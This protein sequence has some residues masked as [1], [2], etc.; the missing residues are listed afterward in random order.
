M[1]RYHLEFVHLC[2]LSIKFR[3]YIIINVCAFTEVLAVFKSQFTNN[4]IIVVC[5]RFV[6]REQTFLWEPEAWFGG[7]GRIGNSPH[8][9]I[10]KGW[11]ISYNFGMM[12][13]G[14]SIYKKI[15][16]WFSSREQALN[17]WLSELVLKLLTNLALIADSRYD[18][19]DHYRILYH[20]KL[21]TMKT[22]YQNIKILV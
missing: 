3:L 21:W 7:D 22:I 4:A 15:L 1:K 2:L 13:M 19:N 9:K 17:F 18:E 5:K 10:Y 14:N 8:R 11:P 6:A 12:R 16:L 20:Y